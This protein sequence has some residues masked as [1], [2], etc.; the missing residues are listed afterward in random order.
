MIR[1]YKKYIIYLLIIIALIP[2]IS[3]ADFPSGKCST[4]GY[5]IAT[6][7]GINTTKKE[8]ENN[9]LVLKKKNGLN[10]NNQDLD[11]QYLYNATHL[12]GVGDI[13]DVVRQGV[14]D[15]ET[16]TDYDLLEILNGASQKVKT[17]KILLVAH[18][19]GNFYA[20]SFYD[21]VA[22]KTGGVPSESIGVYGVAT[23]SGRVAGGGKYLTSSTDKVISGLVGK[24]LSR[25]IMQPNTNIILSKGDDTWGHSFT[26]VYLKYRPEVI[27]SG[28]QTSL[29]RLKSNTTQDT[30]SLCI[31]PPKLSFLHKAEGAVLAI[32]DP[33]AIN[34]KNKVVATVQGTALVVNYGTVAVSWLYQQEVSYVKSIYNNSVSLVGSIASLYKN[35]TA[36]ALIPTEQN[37]VAA[38]VVNPV[39]ETVINNPILVKKVIEPV[40]VE[41]EMV[42]INIPPVIIEK[43][44]IKTETPEIQKVITPV[45]TQKIEPIEPVNYNPSLVFTGSSPIVNTTAS[46]V[47][48]RT[49]I[50]TD[51]TIS[52]DHIEEVVD[53]IVPDPVVIVE[54]GK[55]INFN[56]NNKIIYAG[57]FSICDID[58]N[59]VVSSGYNVGMT[60]FISSTNWNTSYQQTSNT[61]MIANINYRFIFGV[62]AQSNLDCANRTHF[63]NYSNNFYYKTEMGD[64]IVYDPESLNNIYSF[65]IN[66]PIPVVSGVLDGDKYTIT[67]FIPQ[68]TDVSNL[69]PTILIPTGSS[70]Y[71]NSGVPTDFTNPVTYTVTSISG[72][73]QDYV[74]SVVFINGNQI[75]FDS[76][77]KIDYRGDFIICS[78]DTRTVY[79]SGSNSGVINFISSTNWNTPY[80]Q[81]P[82]VN[83]D[84]NKNLYFIFGGAV[85][86]INDCKNNTHSNNY[87]NGFYYTA[88]D[89][90]SVVYGG[91]SPAVSGVEL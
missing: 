14:F 27:I 90:L 80:Q 33:V 25:K 52:N 91:Y 30:Q 83:M 66:N 16:V 37:Q 3:L 88:P 34:T 71:P 64:S 41:P 89:G 68:G 65:D 43:N 40:I 39:N 19:Q 28:I 56:S 46:N 5:T 85:A 78:P 86:S 42:T 67:L 82:N 29:D 70:I 31:N 17:Q 73:K 38:S 15:N 45:L 20:N 58:S 49:E 72:L 4:D 6:I 47:V 75:D 35:N 11:Y 62:P 79:T 10:N 50:I 2:S 55:Q 51:S 61:N 57:E 22:N 77:N 81:T 9:M 44:I 48:D 12:A 23:P 21:T 76:S 63:N 74:V 26:D 13:F 87:S 54:N 7:N 1:E 18:S 53:P 84:I 69:I 59:I 24:T 60:D 8:A 36:T 32:A